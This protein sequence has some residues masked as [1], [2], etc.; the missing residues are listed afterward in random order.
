MVLLKI[1]ILEF[2]LKELTF[3]IRAIPQF[4]KILLVALEQ[5]Q[6]RV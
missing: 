4:R 3:W 6:S 1:S 2:H 5:Y